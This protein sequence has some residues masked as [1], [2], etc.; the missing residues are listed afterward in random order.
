MVS[1]MQHNNVLNLPKFLSIKTICDF[2]DEHKGVSYHNY[3]AYVSAN[4]L[5]KFILKELI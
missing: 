1:I 3:A 4:F 5:Y 2:A